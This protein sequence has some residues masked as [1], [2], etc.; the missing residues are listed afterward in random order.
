[1]TD[2]LSRLLRAHALGA[3]RPGEVTMVNITHEDG[4]LRP[5]G[6]PCTCQPDLTAESG[7]GV[8]DIDATGNPSTT[9]RGRQ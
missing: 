3:F 6:G 4:C 2:Y 5:T 7:A 8:Q 9:T 1:M